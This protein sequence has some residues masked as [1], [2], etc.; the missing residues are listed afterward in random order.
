MF[1]AA[2]G[3]I[4]I[5]FSG[6]NPVPDQSLGFSFADFHQIFRQFFSFSRFG[7]Q[8]GQ[9]QSGLFAVRH[10]CSLHIW[11]SLL[12][13]EFPEQLRIVMPEGGFKNAT[14]LLSKCCNSIVAAV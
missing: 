2:R 14:F 8:M 7:G 9:F 11:F 10:H 4:Q 13:I 5:I 1:D 12:L 3:F 6:L